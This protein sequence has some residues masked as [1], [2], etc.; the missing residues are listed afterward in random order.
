MAHSVCEEE[1]DAIRAWLIQV[2]ELRA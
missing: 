2:L 1:I